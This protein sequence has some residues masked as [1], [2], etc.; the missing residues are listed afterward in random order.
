MRP[1]LAESLERVILVASSNGEACAPKFPTVSTKYCGR[2]GRGRTCTPRIRV[3]RKRLWGR[4]GRGA[5]IALLAVVSVL[6]L[7][8]A[9]VQ[10]ADAASTKNKDAAFVA[11][12]LL[13]AATANPDQL[14]NV[15]VQAS[16]GENANNVGNQVDQQTGTQGG[17]S[18]QQGQNGNDDRKPGWKKKF[19]VISGVSAKLRGKDI[20]KLAKNSHIASITL[21]YTVARTS[22]SNPQLWPDAAQVAS[23][24]PSLDAGL[25]TPTVAVVDSGIDATHPDIAGQVIG[26]ATS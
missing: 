2:L 6:A 13:S 23:F 17:Q 14:F 19:S 15:I 21:D 26:S 24:W 3:A 1:I 16:P 4:G 20:V 9:D 12:G 25:L 10:L 22:S 11:K 8:A 7:A 5:R 18:G